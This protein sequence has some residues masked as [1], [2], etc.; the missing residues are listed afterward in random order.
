MLIRCSD[1]IL[2]NTE[3]V[4]SFFTR[5]R[6]RGYN[7]KITSVTTPG[8]GDGVCDLYEVCA[9]DVNGETYILTKPLTKHETLDVLD[10]IH[11]SVESYN[12]ERAIDDSRLVLLKIG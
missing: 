11:K 5:E 4:I 10:F 8:S 1:D 7:A 12:Q 9:G 6:P 2:L 3:F